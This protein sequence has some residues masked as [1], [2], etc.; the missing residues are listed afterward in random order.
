M[1]K[2]IALLLALVMVLGLAAG[3]ET[4]APVATQAPTEGGNET[5]TEGSNENPL[6]GT[7]D[8]IMWV[9]ESDG[10]TAMTQ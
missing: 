1:K 8:I 2:I 6:A 4:P 3:G 5:P 9:S 10:M 7:Y